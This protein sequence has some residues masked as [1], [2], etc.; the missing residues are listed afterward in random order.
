MTF[1]HTAWSYKPAGVTAA[2]MNLFYGLAVIAL[3]RDASVRQYDERRL[4]DPAVLGFIAR[5][6]ASEDDSLEARAPFSATHAGC[7]LQRAMAALFTMSGWHAAA[8]RRMR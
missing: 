8:V 6:S 1:V 3:H 2:Q 5:I 4:A 7:R